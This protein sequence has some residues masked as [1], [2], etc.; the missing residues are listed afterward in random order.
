MLV[1][2]NN[3]IIQIILITGTITIVAVSIT[4]MLLCMNKSISIEYTSYILKDGIVGPLEKGMLIFLLINIMYIHNIFLITTLSTLLVR[5]L[6]NRRERLISYGFAIW[7]V[8]L[9]KLV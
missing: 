9:N 5:E 4:R 1:N 8:T 7:H 2:Y 6:F 3:Q